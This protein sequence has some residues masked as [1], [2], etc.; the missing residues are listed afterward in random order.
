MVKVGRRFAVSVNMRLPQ[1]GEK[2]VVKVFLKADR[3]RALADRIAS[4]AARRQLLV[5]HVVGYQK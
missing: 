2:S 1:R 5:V 3:T 4:I